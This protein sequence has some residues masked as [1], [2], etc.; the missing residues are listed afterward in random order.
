M[1]TIEMSSASG[2]EGCCWRRVITLLKISRNISRLV[3]RMVLSTGIPLR[4]A[5]M[6]TRARSSETQKREQGVLTTI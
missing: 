5:T 3:G 6:T 2:M 1:T 4:R